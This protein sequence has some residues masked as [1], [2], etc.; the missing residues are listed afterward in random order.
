MQTASALASTNTQL[1]YFVS[2]QHARQREFLVRERTAKDGYY[3][4]SIRY[5]YR[6]IL[7]NTIGGITILQL[8]CDRHHVLYM[9][10]FRI[11]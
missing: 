7:S 5:H 9:V 8:T 2:L 3:A 11:I 1:W 4:L 10:R 6:Y